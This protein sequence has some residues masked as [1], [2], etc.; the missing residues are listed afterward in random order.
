M[1]FALTLRLQFAAGS[2]PITLASSQPAAEYLFYQAADGQWAFLSSLD[3]RILASA[4]GSLQACPR[5][6]QAPIVGLEHVVQ[7]EATRRR[8]KHLTH[9]PLTGERMI[10][11]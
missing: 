1:I 4:N 7:T 6:L 2:S 11:W 10:V 3:L 8:F 9:I 5:S